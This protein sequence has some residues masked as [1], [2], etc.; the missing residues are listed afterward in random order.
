MTRDLHGGQ[1]IGRTRRLQLQRHTGPRGASAAILSR[2]DTLS[3]YHACALGFEGRLSANRGDITTAERLL[4]ASLR[5]LREVRYEVL[6]TP[7]LS[8]LAEVLA[9][10]DRLD[11]GLAAAGKALQ[12]T[13]CNNAFWWMPEALRI[14]G[15]VLVLSDGSDTR[16]AEDHSRRSLDLA[17]RRGALSWKLRAVT[18]LGRLQR[19]QGRRP[20]ARELLASI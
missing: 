19:D 17:H 12:R 3:S 11:D 5:G 6:C 4:R 20:E 1:S 13:K 8:N 14:K 18:S 9:K 10:T 2:Y 15:G 7:F 16:A